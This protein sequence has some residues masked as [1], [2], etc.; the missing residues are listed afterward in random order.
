MWARASPKK[1]SQI[2][3]GEAAERPIHG[4]AT[5]QEVKEL[6]EEGVPFL[7]SAE[8]RARQLIRESLQRH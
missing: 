4:T 3:K 2:H 8:T 5:L 6:A 7:P 1:P